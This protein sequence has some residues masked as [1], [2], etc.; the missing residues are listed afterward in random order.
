MTTCKLTWRWRPTIAVW[1]SLATVTTVPGA[2]QVG[3][4][5]VPLEVLAEDDFEE[6]R[7]QWEFHDPE[8][9]QYA[10]VEDRTVLSQFVK[11]SSY[12]PPHR[13]P[14]HVALL[15]DHVVGDFDLTVS[16]RSTEPD[17]GH[18][19]ACLFFG[20]VD[21]AHFYYVHLGKK[22]D[23]HAN[24]IFIVN[25]ADRQAIS[26]TT[27]EGT[28]WDDQWHRVKVTRRVAT[29][30]IEVF[31]DNF[32]EPVMTAED[33]TFPAGRV[34]LGSFDDRADWDDFELRG[35]PAE[36]PTAAADE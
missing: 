3:A 25:G 35:V 19:D 22:T 15:K 29:G 16:V 12:R 7:R 11:P 20:Y 1:L 23:P 24:Q 32:D 36:L 34:G 26:L 28:N 10:V 13:S 2:A 5:E 33:K 14:Y 21:A 9:W 4:D 18:R 31:F 6:N 8:A 30:R 27:T 17:Y